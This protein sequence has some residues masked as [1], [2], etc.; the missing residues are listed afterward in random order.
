MSGSVESIDARPVRKHRL[1]TLLVVLAVIVVLIFVVVLTLAPII[2]LQTGE[3]QSLRAS[4][5]FLNRQDDKAQVEIPLGAEQQPSAAE[6]CGNPHCAFCLQQIQGDQVQENVEVEKIEAEKV[7]SEPRL[8]HESILAY[9]LPASNRLSQVPSK[10]WIQG[11]T[12]DARKAC[13]WFVA[14]KRHKEM[15]VF[16]DKTHAL[17]SLRKYMNEHQYGVLQKAAILTSFLGALRAFR[18]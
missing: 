18:S 9:H 8:T 14:Q 11:I 13:A 16:L 4:V 15:E 1:S 3:I 12:D 5:S 7:E 17:A 10:Q 6:T 2:Y